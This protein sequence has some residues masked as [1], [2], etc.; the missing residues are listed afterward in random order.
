MEYRI[1]YKDELYHHGVKG[2]KWGVRKAVSVAGRLRNGPRVDGPRDKFGRPTSD[3]A[4]NR[5]TYDRNGRMRKVNPPMDTLR[6]ADR[7]SRE[8]SST[9]QKAAKSVKTGAKIAK[10]QGLKAKVKAYSKAADDASRKQDKADEQ[11][12][13]V[14]SQYK[15][16][17]K[18]PISRMKEVHKAQIGKG[19][20]AAKKYLKDWN[21]WEKSQNAADAAERRRKETRKETGRTGLSRT[22]NYV[23]YSRG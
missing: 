19:S 4:G 17:G 6:N 11:W 15:A 5:V 2:M 22:V 16:L 20:E 14:K 10:Q 8:M 13:S 18:T 7:R 9:I 3:M 23:R 21:S 1:I 12:R